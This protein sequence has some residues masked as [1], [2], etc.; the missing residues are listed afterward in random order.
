ME[1]VKHMNTFI[2][3]FLARLVVGII[4]VFRNQQLKLKM[5]VETPF[6]KTLCAKLWFQIR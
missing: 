1:T 3:K 6:S 5:K 2:S 4:Q